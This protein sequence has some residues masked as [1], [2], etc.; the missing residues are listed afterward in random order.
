ML[1]SIEIN[2]AQKHMP[3]YGLFDWFK[4]KEQFL[5]YK[6]LQSGA[7]IVWDGIGDWFLDIIIDK[8]LDILA[9]IVLNNEFIKCNRHY[10]DLKNVC[11][12]SKLSEINDDAGILMHVGNNFATFEK[13]VVKHILKLDSNILITNPNYIHGILPLLSQEQQAR[14]AYRLSD[15]S[16]SYEICKLFYQMYRQNKELSTPSPL[17]SYGAQRILI[18]KLD[19]YEIAYLALQETDTTGITIE[20]LNNILENPLPAR[21]GPNPNVGDDGF[22][23]K[24]ID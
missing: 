7:D 24:I 14:V 5:Y 1:D 23:Y 2:Q 10:E 22:E 3:G 4:Q 6:K 8:K 15:M 17:M 11:R 9:E 13:E 21:D 20:T 12:Y 19:K 16:P 18:E